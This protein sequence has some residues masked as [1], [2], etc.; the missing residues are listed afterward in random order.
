MAS[1]NTVVDVEDF[2]AECTGGEANGCC[3]LVNTTGFAEAN[4][5]GYGVKGCGNTYAPVVV[6][7][8][9]VDG[10]GSRDVAEGVSNRNVVG[11][12]F[13]DL[14]NIVD[15]DSVKTNISQTALV[16]CFTDFAN[17]QSQTFV[18]QGYFW[19]TD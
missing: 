14:C 18:G 17:G 10:Q 9:R 16:R 6:R 4:S 5:D 12:E 8:V 7:A 11:T 2:R 19:V 1:V 3:G 15:A 13:A